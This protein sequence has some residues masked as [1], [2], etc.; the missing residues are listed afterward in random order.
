[1]V[2]SSLSKTATYLRLRKSGKMGLLGPLCLLGLVFSLGGG[3]ARFWVSCIIQVIA[4]TLETEVV[5]LV[6]RPLL[7]YQGRQ[8][9]HKCWGRHDQEPCAPAHDKASLCLW[10]VNH[11]VISSTC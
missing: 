10:P 1:M 5:P 3:V 8:L 11:A 6:T 2:K 9:P 4:R 7:Q